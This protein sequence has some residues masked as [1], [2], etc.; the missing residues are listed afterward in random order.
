MTS[1]N[2]EFG[3]ISIVF[4]FHIRHEALLLFVKAIDGAINGRNLG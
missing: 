3:V 4:P 2:V 1:V